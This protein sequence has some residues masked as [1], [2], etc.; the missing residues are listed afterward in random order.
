MTPASVGV[1]AT[2]IVL[3]KHSGRKALEHKLNALGHSVTRDELDQV[4]QRF[5]AL[6]DRKKS[7]YDQDL[8]GLLKAGST[9][10]SA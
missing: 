5:T 7:I 8:I 9:H 2:N 10:V 3:G 4:Y 1:P 6:A